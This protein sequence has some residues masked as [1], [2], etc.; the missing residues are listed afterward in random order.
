MVRRIAAVL[1]LLLALATAVWGVRADY[2]QLVE[3][4]AATIGQDPPFV[5]GLLFG[6]EEMT[7]LWL[8][9]AIATLS[10]TAYVL[11]SGLPLVRPIAGALPAVFLV[12][13][14]L[15]GVVVLR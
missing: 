13:L 12:A 3:T 5:H 4:G 2:R 14:G 6:G 15:C 11:R 10:I 7:T 8:T 9:L 1:F